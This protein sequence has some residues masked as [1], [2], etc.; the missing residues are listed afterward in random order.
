VNIARARQVAALPLRRTPGGGLEVLLVTSRETQRWIIP[1]GWPWP[2]HAD[3]DAAAGEAHEE[4]GIFGRVETKRFGTYVY[5][6]HQPGETIEVGVD[7]YLFWVTEELADWKEREERERT[8]FAV[9]TA[10]TAVDEPQL[11]ALLRA[12]RE[13]PRSRG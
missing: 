12:L 7:V 1:K 13:L 11:Q 3:H 5:D 4:A 6:K 2:D 9:E 8:W 10:A